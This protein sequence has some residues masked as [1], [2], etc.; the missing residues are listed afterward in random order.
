MERIRDGHDYTS[1]GKDVPMIDS[2]LIDYMDYR[3]ETPLG[4]VTKNQLARLAFLAGETG[5][6]QKEIL[7]SDTWWSCGSDYPS[8]NNML[9]DLVIKAREVKQKQL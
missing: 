7:E 1:T 9:K 8:N 3:T 5:E 6:V 4:K 2:E